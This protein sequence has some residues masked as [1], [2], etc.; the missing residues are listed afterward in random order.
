M[1]A[2]VVHRWLGYNR[3]VQAITKV[4]YP[5]RGGEEVKLPESAVVAAEMENGALATYHLGAVSHHPQANR[6]EMHGSEGTLIASLA[7]NASD[8]QGARKGEELRQIPVPPEERRE[9][10]AEAEFIRAIREGGP[11][12]PDFYEG[13]KYMEFTEAVWRSSE[14]GRSVELPLE[15]QAV[16]AR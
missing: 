12:T 10:L 9:W 8:I 11:V 7:A 5:R 3:R 1:Y 15:K 6:V 2:E 14:E 4:H 13:L 16:A